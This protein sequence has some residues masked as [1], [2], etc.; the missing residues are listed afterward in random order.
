MLD[1]NINTKRILKRRN[2]KIQQIR[3]IEEKALNKLR[4][5]FQE[6][7]LLSD[8]LKLEFLQNK[9]IFFVAKNKKLLFKAKNL[10]TIAT[11][12]INFLRQKRLKEQKR[13]LKEQVRNREAFLKKQKEQEQREHQINK[14]FLEPCLFDRNELF[15]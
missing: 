8:Y 9:K 11:F 5:N 3:E 1:L 14:L 15:C 7:S 4:T 13:E 10:K 2:L 12:L 6:L